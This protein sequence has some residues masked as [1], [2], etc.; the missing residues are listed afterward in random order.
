MRLDGIKTCIKELALNICYVQRE[1]N[2]VLVVPLIKTTP[3]FQSHCL[4]SPNPVES[5][6]T[7]QYVCV[8]RV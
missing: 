7:A 6:A 3:S 1:Q 4:S 5:E 8:F 2:P